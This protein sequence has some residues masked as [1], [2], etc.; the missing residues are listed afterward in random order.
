MKLSPLQMVHSQF[1]GISLIA[2]EMEMPDLDTNGAPY[3]EIKGEH[4]NTEVILGTP[5]DESEP[6][7][8]SIKLSIDNLKVR[9]DDFPYMFA[10]KIEGI[11]NIDHDGDFTERK[12][13]VV[14]NGTAMLY[15]LIREQFLMLSSRHK[16]GPMQLPSLDFRVLQE[17]KPD[18]QEPTPPVTV[19]TKKP[20]R[21]KK[22]A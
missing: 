3:P 15:G 10:A 12:R 19:Q 6:T 16:H 9:P 1:E 11:F 21:K 4:I 22:P 8:F 20:A 17:N 7:R 18:D 13:M 14:I 5:P 2:V